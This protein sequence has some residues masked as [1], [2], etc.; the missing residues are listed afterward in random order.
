MN[1]KELIKTRKS[2]RTFDGR[3]I[4]PEDREKLCAYIKDIPNPWQNGT[5]QSQT[6]VLRGKEKRQQGK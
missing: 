6:L 4:D 3:P 1:V 5:P 2:V